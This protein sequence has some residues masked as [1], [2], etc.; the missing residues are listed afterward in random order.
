MDTDDKIAEL[1]QR[2]EMLKEE[3]STHTQSQAVEQSVG[4]RNLATQLEQLH[5]DLIRLKQDM[6]TN[7]KT[8]QERIDRVG[9]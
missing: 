8:L 4:A 5:S 7:M 2:I 6:E 3:L 9:N 1:E